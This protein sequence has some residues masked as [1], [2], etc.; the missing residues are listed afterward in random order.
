MVPGNLTR[1]EIVSDG[2]RE[3]N[4]TRQ[5][6]ELRMPDGARLQWFNEMLLFGGFVIEIGLNDEYDVACLLIDFKYIIP[7]L[8]CKECEVSKLLTPQSPCSAT[9]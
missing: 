1:I 7:T 6:R 4:L 3:G 8:G 9:L 5:T 2:S